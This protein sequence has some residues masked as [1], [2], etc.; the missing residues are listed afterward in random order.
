MPIDRIEVIQPYI[1][2]LWEERLPATISLGM[3][4][5]NIANTICG[6]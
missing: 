2:A 5:I 1:I 4:T 3:E 6:I